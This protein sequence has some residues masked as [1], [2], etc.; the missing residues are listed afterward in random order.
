MNLLGLEYNSVGNHEF[1]KGVAELKR[2]QAGGC[3]K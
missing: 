1:D 2:M 3:A